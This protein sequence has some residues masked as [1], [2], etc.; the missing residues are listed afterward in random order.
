MGKQI[1]KQPDV[2]SSNEAIAATLAPA[3]WRA[4]I[5]AAYAGIPDLEPALKHDTYNAIERLQAQV[6]SSGCG[7]EQR[8]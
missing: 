5:E 4:V 8:S 7:H 1:I 6:K 2:K 3:E